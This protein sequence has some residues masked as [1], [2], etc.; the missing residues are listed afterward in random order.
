MKSL[1]AREL[2]IAEL[3]ITKGAGDCPWLDKKG[4]VKSTRYTAPKR[5]PVNA[6][7]V[8][9]VQAEP[10]QQRILARKAASFTRQGLQKSQCNHV[11]QWAPAA[12]GS[13]NKATLYWNREVLLTPGFVPTI[14]EKHGKNGWSSGKGQETNQAPERNFPVG[15]AVYLINKKSLQRLDQSLYAIKTE[16]RWSIVKDSPVLQTEIVQRST[17]QKLEI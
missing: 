9:A 1:H 16:K 3:K 11:V 12:L 6:Q 4:Q 17:L 5:C 7:E 15:K 8:Q 14:K 10:G 2:K 13:V